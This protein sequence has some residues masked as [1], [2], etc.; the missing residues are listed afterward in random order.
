MKRRIKYETWIFFLQNI[1]IFQEALVAS[2]F[3]FHI[4]K[5][6]IPLI[7]QLIFTGFTK[8]KNS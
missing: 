7:I 6:A 5:Q 4:M 2:I 1:L 8:T 3:M